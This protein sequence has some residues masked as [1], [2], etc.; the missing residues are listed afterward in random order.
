MIKK[1]SVKELATILGCSLTAVNKKIKADDNNPEI[2]RYRNRY[3]TVVEENVTYIL[4]DDEA[5]EDE[6]RRSKGFKA[7]FTNVSNTVSNEYETTDY[8][9][10]EPVLQNNNQDKLLEF[11]QRYINDFTTLQ[12][13]FYDEMRQKDQQI[14]LL[15]TSENQKQAEYLET[16]AKNKQLIKQNNVLKTILTVIITL[17]VTLVITFVCLNVAKNKNTESA[18]VSK[19]ENVQETLPQP[20]AKPV[21]TQKK[22][23]QRTNTY[24]KRTY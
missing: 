14:Y 9:D 24:Q 8:I 1:Y 12:K 6:K 3:Q 7:G 13:T 22:P 18:E 19:V 20:V 4:L 23:V 16:Q 21:A 11:T 10:V 17:V 15:T 2:K 5:L